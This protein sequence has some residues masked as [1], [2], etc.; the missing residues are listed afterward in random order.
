MSNRDRARGPA[1]A[2]S[3]PGL[4][5]ACEEPAAD[6]SSNRSAWI[7][8]PTKTD[9][10]WPEDEKTLGTWLGSLDA[11]RIDS[12]HGHG[13]AERPR[14]APNQRVARHF[15]TPQQTA[16]ADV[17]ATG[18]CLGGPGV[19]QGYSKYKLNFEDAGLDLT[20]G[21]RSG[22]YLAGRATRLVR[23]G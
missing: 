23:Y 19:L 7:S 5:N 20:I 22:L 4:R 10:L 12:V 17:S 2:M 9:S 11:S 3:G 1:G 6:G 18:R 8:T 21:V 16:R 13:S 15:R 14:S